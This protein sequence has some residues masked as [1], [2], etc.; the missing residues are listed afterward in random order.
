MNTPI[1]K[2][3]D[4]A[5]YEFSFLPPS[6][7]LKVL[8]R[9]NKLL[10]PSL[11]SIFSKLGKGGLMD[12]D[13]SSL[14]FESAATMLAERMDED[15]ILETIKELVGTVRHKTGMEVNFD[16]DFLGKPLHLLKVVK[17]AL[18]VNYGDF[19]VELKGGLKKIQTSTQEKQ[20]SPG[21]SGE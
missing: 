9:I 20:T 21:K 7:A 19:F 4:G 6:T 17:A 18:E 13:F 1:K 16:V 14:N 2:K 12:T 10:L 11:G 3:V 5:E 8:A 15:Q